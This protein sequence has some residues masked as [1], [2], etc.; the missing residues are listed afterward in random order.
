MNPTLSYPPPLTPRSGMIL[1]RGVWK[2][3]YTK[4]GK[5]LYRSLKT[6]DEILAAMRRDAFHAELRESGAVEG[7]GRGRPKGRKDASKR[8]PR[9]S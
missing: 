5:R 1:S 8:K 7:P 9:V 3:E 4:D 6:D 2:A